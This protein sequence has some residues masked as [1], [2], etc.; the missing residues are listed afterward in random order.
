MK[1]KRNFITIAMAAVVLVS[2]CAVCVSTSVSAATDSGSS[3]ASVK[4]SPNLVGTS[5]AAGTG[6]S[7]CTLQGSST[8]DMWLFADG[9]DGALWYGIWH[10][11]STGWSNQWTSLGGGLSS[12]PCAVS[13]SSGVMDVYVRGNDG[14]VWLRACHSGTWDN[15]YNLG[16]LVAPGTAPAASGWSGREDVFAKG[17]DGIMY[18][19]TWTPASGWGSWTRVGGQLTSSPAAVSRG[20]G[21]IEVHARGTDAADWYT[22]YYNGAW[23]P[24]I[25]LGGQIA[26]GTGPAAGAWDVNSFAP[27][28]P[29]EGVFVAGTDG[30]MYQK[31][32]TAASGW[33]GWQNLGGQLKS[34]PTV[35]MQGHA[36]EILVRWSN[37][38]IYLKE[39]WSL[40]W[41]NW[42]Q[43]A[44]QGPP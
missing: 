27:H 26:S 20:T 15:W 14:A 19:K 44:F 22:S 12:S 4:A 8:S 5:M 6:P 32:W 31:I 17:M 35:A 29:G 41:H 43:T 34:S 7:W 11:L 37:D 1:R 16:G 3:I 33:S 36:I 9:H 28:P 25:S 10:P 13:R 40:A 2:L 24:W 23:H 21:L 18:Q 39:Y 38:Y 42:L 30:A